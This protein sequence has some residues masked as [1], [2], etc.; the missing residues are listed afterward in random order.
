MKVEDHWSGTT[1][2]V[3]LAMAQYERVRMTWR[4]RQCGSTNAFIRKDDVKNLRS[5]KQGEE[6]RDADKSFHCCH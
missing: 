4:L 3:S 2:T 6:R 5:S 1:L